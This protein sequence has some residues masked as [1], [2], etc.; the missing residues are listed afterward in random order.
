VCWGNN[1]RGQLGRGDRINRNTPKGQVSARPFPTRERRDPNQFVATSFNI[2][3]SQHTEPGGGVPEWA[4]GRLRSEWAAN[5]IQRTSTGIMGFQEIQPDQI[6]TLD[7]IIGNRFDFWPGNANGT[8]AAWQTVAW[9]NTK[10]DLVTA[11]NVDLPVL[12]KKRPHPLVLL[13]NKATGKSVWLFNI[14]N[15]S[16]NTPGRKKERRK[17]LKLIVKQVANKRKDG[18][19]LILLG[20]FNDRKE[21]FCTVTGKTDLK[22]T[23]GG[24]HK[25]GKCKPPKRMGIDWIFASKDLKAQSFSRD[26]NPMIL[27][28]TDHP[29]I[30]ST[31]RFK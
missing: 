20:D 12:G 8:R 22:A 28:I 6:N 19:P 11:E 1:E 4:P 25:K 9:D 30:Y 13:R 17:A 26:R 29:V 2:L 16:K 10:W 24:S 3:G 7:R 23:N 31:L 18:T 15:S 27:R 21:A 5:L 14:H